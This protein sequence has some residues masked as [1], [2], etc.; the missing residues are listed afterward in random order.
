MAD[1]AQTAPRPSRHPNHNEHSDDDDD[2][3]GHDGFIFQQQTRGPGANPHDPNVDPLMRRFAEMV[4]GFG[5]FTYRSPPG[6]GHGDSESQRPM[7]WEQQRHPFSR[8]QGQADRD[9]PY[10]EAPPPPHQHSPFDRIPAS[11]IHRTT[12]RTGG[13]GGGTASVTIVSN[14]PLHER[15]TREEGQNTGQDPFAA[16][17]SQSPPMEGIRRTAY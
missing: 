1:Q 7:R 17:V 10:P 14:A 15:G 16:Y 6:R 9:D 13:L 2:N 5:P 3:I 8:D 12:F 4:A 11:Q